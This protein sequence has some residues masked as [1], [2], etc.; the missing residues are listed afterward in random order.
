MAALPPDPAITRAALVQRLL[1][2]GDGRRRVVAFAGP[3]G[4]GKSTV[5]ERLRSELEAARP[6]LAAI[7]PLDGFHFDDVVLELRGD[8]ARKG[9][10]HTFDVDGFAAML[11]RLQRD[12]GRDIAVPVFDRAIEIARAG[13]RIIAGTVR[14]VLAEGNYLLLDR[15]GWRD[16]APLFDLTIMVTASEANLVDRLRRRWLGYGYTEAQL[17]AKMAG[18]DLPNMRLVLAGSRPADHVLRSDA[19]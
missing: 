3:P 2:W 14:I 5:V 4:A 6:G 11:V 1:G 17:E 13:A 8:R 9:A 18:N 12:A 15:P 19:D 7:L 16:L 10:P